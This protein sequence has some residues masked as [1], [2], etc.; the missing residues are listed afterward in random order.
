MVELAREEFEG[1][2]PGPLALEAP[3]TVKELEAA[4]GAGENML[5]LPELNVRKSDILK[6][7][8]QEFVQREPENVAALIR[9]WLTEE[10]GA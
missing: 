9:V 10:D 6:Q 7:R 8:I 4:L 1:A 2:E 5:A 3:K